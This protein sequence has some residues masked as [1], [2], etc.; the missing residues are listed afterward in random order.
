MRELLLSFEDAKSGMAPLKWKDLLSGKALVKMFNW[1]FDPGQFVFQ[2]PRN[3]EWTIRFT[4]DHTGQTTYDNV[5]NVTNTT[6]TI[7]NNTWHNAYE[8]Y[9][10]DYYQ[11]DLYEQLQR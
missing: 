5:I 9:Q 11:N 8:Q 7:P 10:N 6:Y 1:D 2:Q 3:A 4:T